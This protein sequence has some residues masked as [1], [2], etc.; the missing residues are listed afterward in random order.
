MKAQNEKLTASNVLSRVAHWFGH[1]AT[2]GAL[3]VYSVGWLVFEK[4]VIGWDGW[5]TIAAVAMTVIIQNS[6]NRDTSALHA[7]LDCLIDALPGASD[8]LKK[9]EKLEED[10]IE[11]LRPD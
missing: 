5:L 4:V 6:Q 11:R 8:T 1:P 9:A 7:K 2:L 10:E 3:L